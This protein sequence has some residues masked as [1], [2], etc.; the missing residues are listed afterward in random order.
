[1]R[2]RTYGIQPIWLSAYTSLSGGYRTST[3][4][5]K[6][7]TTENM[8]LANPSV[9]VTEG[10]ASAEVAG[11][12][13]DEPMCMHTAVPVSA[14]ASKKGSQCPEW[15]LGTPRCTGIS[16]NATAWTPRAALR[17]TSA[18]PAATSHSGMRQIGMSRPAE[19]PHHSSTIQSL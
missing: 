4:D 3:P 9:A 7:S 6:K 14:H 2:S 8:A 13:E 16:L 17:R 12:R 10:G 1:M 11:I 19:S 18:A 5:H 15:M